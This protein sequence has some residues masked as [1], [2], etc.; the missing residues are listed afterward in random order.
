MNKFKSKNKIQKIQ[1]YWNLM[2]CNINFSKK[3]FLSKQYF[4]EIKKK[5]Y[6]VEKHIIKFAEF[7]KYRNKNV[8]EIGCGIGTDAVEFIKNKAK[9]YGIE[10]SKRSL[11]ITRKRIQVYNLE[12]YNP[13][14]LFDNAENLNKIRKLNIKFDLIY[15]FG[16]LHHTPNIKKCFESIYDICHKD[17]EIKIMLYAE[18]SYKNFLLDVTPYRYESQKGCPVFYRVNKNDL[19]FLIKDK[20][21]IINIKQDFIFPYKI[22]QYKKNQYVKI[23]HFKIMPSTVFRTLE[24]NIGEHLL[25]KLK[26]II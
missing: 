22:K 8:L 14:L 9:Y 13:V 24:K 12:K 17:T 21:Q 25:I 23:N 3:N 18:N 20:F 16:V 26:K 5:K 4:E 7:K 1:K 10:Y 2:P 11:E 19:D 6:F 15:S